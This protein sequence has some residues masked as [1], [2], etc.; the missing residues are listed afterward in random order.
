MI[1]RD[2]YQHLVNNVP[3]VSGRVYQLTFPQNVVK[4]AILIAFVSDGSIQREGFVSL[5]GRK[6]IQIDIYDK[7]FYDCKSVKDEVLAALAT[8]T[9]APQNI[10]AQSVYEKEVFLYRDI[11]DFVCIEPSSC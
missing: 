2:L 1:E 9:P 4:P 7:G 11:L 10:N 6:R 5:G 3:L 8:F